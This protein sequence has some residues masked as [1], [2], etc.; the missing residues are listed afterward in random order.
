M[1]KFSDQYFVNLAFEKNF[2]AKLEKAYKNATLIKAVI[3]SIFWNKHIFVH[4]TFKKVQGERRLRSQRIL[5]NDRLYNRQPLYLKQLLQHFLPL[6]P[7][8]Y[9]LPLQKSSD[10]LKIEFLNVRIMKLATS[11]NLPNFAVS[12]ECVWQK[13]NNHA[14]SFFYSHFLLFLISCILLVSQ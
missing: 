9:L 14:I 2:P 13:L 1:P 4:S 6:Q 8:H 7:V 12:L 11:N 3:R 10:I 5:A